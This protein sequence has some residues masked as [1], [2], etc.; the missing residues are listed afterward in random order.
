M[1]DY[2]VAVD[3]EAMV[4]L[5]AK[6]QKLARKR[7]IPASSLDFG[8]S[9]RL[10]LGLEPLQK[11]PEAQKEPKRPV[12][13]PRKEVRCEIPECLWHCRPVDPDAHICTWHR[14]HLLQLRPEDVAVWPWGHWSASGTDPADGRLRIPKHLSTR[15]WLVTYR[16]EICQAGYHPAEDVD[17]D[18]VRLMAALSPLKSGD[19]LPWVLPS[20]ESVELRVVAAAHNLVRDHK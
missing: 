2:R 5:L 3:P 13:R 1:K 8:T 6:A 19:V 4:L 18:Q 14:A 9:L 15:E 10:V 16:G 12:G 11:A 17:A 20:G 7:L